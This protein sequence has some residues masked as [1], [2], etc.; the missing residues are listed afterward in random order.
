[1]YFF[2]LI[3]LLRKSI[4]IEITFCQRLK[5]Q[6][7]HQLG[8]PISI[9][10]SSTKTL[11]KVANNY[12]KKGEGVFVLTDLLEIDAFLE[13]FS[14]ADLW[15]IGRNHARYLL[16]QGIDTAKDECCGR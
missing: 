16:S 5:L 10:V 7:W 8:I 1:M 11:A 6:V 2:N 4:T 9:G 13:R 14:I 3:T 15:G 12:S